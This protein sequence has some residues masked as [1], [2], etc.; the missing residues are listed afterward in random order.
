MFCVLLDFVDKD[1]DPFTLTV[2]T[3]GIS[4]LSHPGTLQPGLGWR[5]DARHQK[6]KGPWRFLKPI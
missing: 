3:L 1:L 6:G 5:R 4:G 2:L